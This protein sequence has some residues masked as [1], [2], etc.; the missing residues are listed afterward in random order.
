MGAPPRAAVYFD[1]ETQPRAAA[2][3]PAVPPPAVPPP[4][5]RR[6]A[7]GPPSPS[8]S[9]PSPRGAFQPPRLLGVF[10]GEESRGGRVS[11]R[12][13][14]GCVSNGGSGRPILRQASMSRA[15]LLRLRFHVALCSCE[16]VR[17][18]EVVVSTFSA[19]D[20]LLI[21]SGGWEPTP[22]RSRGTDS[23]ARTG[24]WSLR[25]HRSSRTLCTCAWLQPVL[26]LEHQRRERV[27]QGF[28]WFDRLSVGSTCQLC[29]GCARMSSRRR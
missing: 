4:A 15:W 11:S 12:P 7:P 18:T 20:S 1:V 9:R 2:C 22:A 17:G 23:G 13:S 10:I 29:P 8:P 6:R 27:V 5:V 26:N 19:S 14:F 25:S 21:N 28:D 24:S 3:T 16:G